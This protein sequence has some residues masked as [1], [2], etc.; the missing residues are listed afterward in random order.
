MIVIELFLPVVVFLFLF[1]VIFEI[2]IPIIFDKPL[3]GNIKFI[4]S[5]K[6][7]KESEIVTEKIQEDKE[8]NIEKSDVTIEKIDS[9]LSD[10]VVEQEIKPKQKRVY[11]KKEKSSTE[12]PLT[13]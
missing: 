1:I 10:P 4:F 8:F 5:K 9:N 11:K 7:I 6:S 3:F 2:V 12:E 13:Q